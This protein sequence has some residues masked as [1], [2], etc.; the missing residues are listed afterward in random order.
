MN[1]TKIIAKT[2]A[3]T[4][5]IAGW[6]DDHEGDIILEAVLVEEGHMEASDAVESIE[7]NGDGSLS[8][9]LESGKVLDLYVA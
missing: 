7:P 6:G 3:L 5:A 1:A 8:V 9:V 4:T 2:Q